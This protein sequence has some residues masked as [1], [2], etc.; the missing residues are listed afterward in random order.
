MSPGSGSDTLITSH[1]ECSTSNEAGLSSPRSKVRAVA[2]I[3]VHGPFSTNDQHRNPFATPNGSHVRTSVAGLDKLTSM[4]ISGGAN[5]PSPHSAS[6]RD[7]YSDQV[8]YC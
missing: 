2:S 5:T 3:Q 4:P 7:E 1:V 8:L 6:G